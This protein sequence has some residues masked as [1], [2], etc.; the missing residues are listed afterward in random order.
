MS[1]FEDFVKKSQKD[2][3]NL[4]KSI[5]KISTLLKSGMSDEAI[6]E[7]FEYEKLAEAT[8]NNARLLPVA[9]G[10]T[11]AVKKV[12][13]NILSSN[14]VEIKYLETGWFYVKMPFLLP[15][16]EKGNPTYIRTTINTALE[17]FFK[18]KKKILFDDCVIVFKHNYSEDTKKYRDHDNIELNVVVD[19]LALYA[20]IDDA[21]MRCKH[22]YCSSKESADS[23][24]VFVLPYDDFIDFLSNLKLNT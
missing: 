19:A 20:M 14:N 10:A 21:P 4:G 15:K 13:E 22:F 9:S 8:V 24:E 16:K 3:E 2:V 1:K 12:K 7:S 17:D 18:D 5:N 11:Y 6:N 23:T